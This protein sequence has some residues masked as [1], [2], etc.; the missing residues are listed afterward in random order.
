MVIRLTARDV[1]EGGAGVD[2]SSLVGEERRGAVRH[3]LRDANV[4]ARGLGGRDIAAQRSISFAARPSIDSHLRVSERAGVLARIGTAEGQYTI[5]VRAGGA[6]DRR[7][8]DAE[9]LCGD[10]ALRVGVLNNGRNARVLVGRQRAAGQV[11]GTEA[12]GHVRQSEYDEGN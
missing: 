5:R 12:A 2:D 7:E 10:Q 3:S 6:S 1:D 11:F 9:L 8:R 4:V